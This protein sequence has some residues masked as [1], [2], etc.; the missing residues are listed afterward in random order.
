MRHDIILEMVKHYYD[1]IQKESNTEFMYIRKY[2]E[3]NKE[4]GEK[5]KMHEIKVI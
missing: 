2:E 1:T 4:G 5:E 3:E